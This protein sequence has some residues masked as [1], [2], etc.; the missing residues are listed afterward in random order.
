MDKQYKK[1]IKK[2]K[3]LVKDTKK[4]LDKDEKRD[5]LVEAGKKAKKMKDKK[6]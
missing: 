3:S 6:C 4:V 1:I 2:E 5:S